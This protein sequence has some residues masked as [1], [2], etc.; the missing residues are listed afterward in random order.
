[1]ARLIDVAEQGDTAGDPQLAKDLIQAADTGLI[2]YFY[3]A[4][5]LAAAGFNDAALDLV[6]ER[7]AANDHLVRE[8][9]ILLRPAFGAARQNPSIMQ[10]FNRTGQVDYW[11]ETDEWPDFC[12]DPALSWDCK[13][14]ARA[15]D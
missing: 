7:Y 13:L 8:S 14:V 6:E 9:G 12:A 10:W 15:L 4:Q 1:M 3:T 5:L 2:T 11:I